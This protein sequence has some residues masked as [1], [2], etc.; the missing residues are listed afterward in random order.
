MQ[1]IHHGFD[2]DAFIRN[3]DPLPRDVEE[4]LHAIGESPKLL[5]VSHYNYYRNFETLIRALPLLR[6]R[7]PGRSPKLLL[8]CH[9]QPGKNPGI[10]NPSAAAELIRELNAQDSVVELGPVRYEQ[11]H[12]LYARADVYVTPAYTETFAHPLVE[13]MASGVPVVA[14]DLEVHREI[15]G[16]AAS[17]FPKFSPEVSSERIAH[18][19]L[20]PETAT[21]NVT[22]WDRARAP[23]LLESSR[24][25][26][27]GRLRDSRV[28]SPQG[29][30]HCRD[31]GNGAP[32]LKAAAWLCG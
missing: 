32:F 6:S 31:R 18:V 27:T 13:A 3:P 25:K 26:N 10:Y 19:L 15:C 21:V 4:K 22:N 24:G 8:T 11:L 1:A 5:F 9:L 20:S 28:V 7:M 30:R 16:D 23:V 12:R 2:R 29:S 14:S 17:Y